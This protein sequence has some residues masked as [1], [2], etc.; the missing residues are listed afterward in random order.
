MGMP[1]SLSLATV[2]V[3]LLIYVAVNSATVL[4]TSALI[5]CNKLPLPST[6][7]TPLG[8]KINISQT[9]TPR[10]PSIYPLPHNQITHHGRPT[11]HRPHN[12]EQRQHGRHGAH[13]QYHRTPQLAGE[14]AA[15]PP[16]RAGSQGPPY[17]AR[18]GG[19]ARLAGQSG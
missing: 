17:L 9:E 6:S 5:S 2:H 12:R 18:Y 19:G 3:K 7:F 1:A 4:T 10:H 16:G 8:P 11:P 13:N 15:A 14:G